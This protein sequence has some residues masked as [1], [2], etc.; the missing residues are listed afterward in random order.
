MLTKGPMTRAEI[1][2]TSRRGES[3]VKQALTSLVRDGMIRRSERG[4][5]APVLAAVPA[6]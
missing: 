2:A 1:I 6:S 4:V 3:S 5:Y